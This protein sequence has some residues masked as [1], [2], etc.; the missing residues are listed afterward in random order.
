MD[1]SKLI[2]LMVNIASLT[3][4]FVIGLK[5]YHWFYVRKKRDGLTDCKYPYK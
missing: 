4:G 2:E 3:V 5:T 1:I